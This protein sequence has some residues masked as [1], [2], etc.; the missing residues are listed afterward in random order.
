MHGRFDDREMDAWMQE[1]E[2]DGCRDGWFQVRA[3]EVML[4]ASP[5]LPDLVPLAQPVPFAP[6]PEA[7]SNPHQTKASECV[8]EL[9]LD[10]E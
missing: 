7:A 6:A 9:F 1:R 10:F 2:R 4:H 5:L 3:A 8:Y